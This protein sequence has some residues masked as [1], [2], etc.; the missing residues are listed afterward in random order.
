V[1]QEFL[2]VLVTLQWACHLADVHPPTIK[3]LK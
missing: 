1:N 2:S 3:L